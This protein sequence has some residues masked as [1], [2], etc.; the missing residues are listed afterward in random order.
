M[1]PGFVS[2]IVLGHSAN[3]QVVSA[4]HHIKMLISEMYRKMHQCWINM[5]APHLPHQI[6]ATNN[7]WLRVHYRDASTVYMFTSHTLAQTLSEV[8][9]QVR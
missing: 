3:Y 6:C 1:S 2:Q 4:E 5:K 8:G 9:Y 7:K